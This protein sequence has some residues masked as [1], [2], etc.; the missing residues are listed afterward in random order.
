M[1][2]FRPEGCTWNELC[3]SKVSVVNKVGPLFRIR[4]PDNGLFIKNIAFN[5]LESIMDCKRPLA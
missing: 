3:P 5:N 1:I 4:V 2:G